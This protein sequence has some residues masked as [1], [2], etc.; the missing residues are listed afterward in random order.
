[1]DRPIISEHEMIQETEGFYNIYMA[2][3][4]EITQ[5]ES[6]RG[7]LNDFQLMQAAS[8]AKDTMG[9]QG[10]E[11]RQTIN[12]IFEKYMH[13][14]R[15]FG[16][17]KADEWVAVTFGYELPEDSERIGLENSD[18][19]DDGPRS[20]QSPNAGQR[21]QELSQLIGE[22]ESELLQLYREFYF[23]QQLAGHPQK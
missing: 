2:F 4:D 20:E 13:I 12:S 16:R 6:V 11:R 19:I 7:K 8:R 10:W 3:L 18:T 22:K 21:L 23:L 17:A 9:I 15:V 1:M 14:Y 5:I